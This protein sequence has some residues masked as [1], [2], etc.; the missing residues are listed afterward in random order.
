MSICRNTA[1][2]ASRNR[3]LTIVSPG[4]T[5]RNITRRISSFKPPTVCGFP[6]SNPAIW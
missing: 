5:R 2:K 1:E 3:R 6:P 4:I